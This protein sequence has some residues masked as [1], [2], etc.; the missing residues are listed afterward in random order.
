[1]YLLVAVAT[2][3]SLGPSLFAVL[4]CWR[5]HDE[6][7]QRKNEMNMM[8][9]KKYKYEHLPKTPVTGGWA[10]ETSRLQWS[11]IIS[12]VQQC[13]LSEFGQAGE[14]A[15]MQG[16]MWRF[17]PWCPT[18]HFSGGIIESAAVNLKLNS[19]NRCQKKLNCAFHNS[20]WATVIAKVT[21][22]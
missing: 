7:V 8:F 1:M 17:H 9:P 5:R 10:S 6:S 16:S 18:K 15:A 4:L 20:I 22:R 11:R 2:R 3:M 13:R 12:Q 21:Q 19:L 14:G